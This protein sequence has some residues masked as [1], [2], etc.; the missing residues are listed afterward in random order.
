MV[1]LKMKEPDHRKFS[2]TN[3]DLHQNSDKQGKNKSQ[4]KKLESNRKLTSNIP[5]KPKLDQFHSECISLMSRYRKQVSGRL[6]G[7]W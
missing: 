3:I 4:I 5:Q 7:K 6:V 1:G 2:S